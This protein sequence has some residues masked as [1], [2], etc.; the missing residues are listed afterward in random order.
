MKKT[1]LLKPFLTIYIGILSI[2]P[3]QAQPSALSVIPEVKTFEAFDGNLLIDTVATI[4]VKPSERKQLYPIALQLQKEL[5][6]VG[7]KTSIQH[8]P[9][10]QLAI[11]LQQHT[12]TQKQ[13]TESY[14]LHIA[15]DITLSG[16][17][18]IGTY[19]ATRTLLQLILHHDKRLPKGHITDYPDYPNRGF[20]LDVGRKFFSIDLLRHYIKLLSYYKMNEFHIHLNDNG[21]KTDYDNDWS[22][23][24]AAFRL[25]SHT[26][27]GLTA[28]DGHYTKEEFRQ[29][30]LMGQQ[31]GV[32]VIPEIDIPA[33][34]LVFT[35]Y[36][37]Q[38]QAAPP[39]APDH[40][41]ILDDEKLPIIYDFFDK[42]L[43][44]YI[45]G[46]QPTFVGNDVH[47]GTDEF[48]KEGDAYNVDNRQAKRFREFTQHYIDYLANKGKT[49]RLWGGLKWIEDSPKTLVKPTGG[50]IMN[51]W[52]KDWVAP[53]EMLNDGFK[54]INTCDTWLYIV[55]QA[56]Y[57]RDFLDTEWLYKS[58]T[59]SKISTEI[60]LP[61][62]A[63]GLLGATFAV[64]NDKCKNGISQLDVHLRVLPA[65]QVMATK[66]WHTAP[67]KSWEAYSSTASQH[68]EGVGRNLIG[69]YT[70][71][72]LTQMSDNIG[73][74]PIIL[75]GKT[76]LS[77][78]GENLSYDY[79]VSFDLYP[80]GE[81]PSDAILFQSNYGVVTLNTAESGKIGFSRDGYI[82]YFDYI[83]T[84]EVWQ[85]LSIVGNSTSVTLFVDGVLVEKLTSYKRDGYLFQQTFHFPIQMLG[86]EKNGFV[87]MIKNL[88]FKQSILPDRVT[89]KQPL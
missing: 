1:G 22:K 61:E 76:T 54:L 57:Y 53:H 87:G 3:L 65:M 16:A 35:R 14:T 20:M 32:N 39:Y 24:Y 37:P 79:T 25:E 26:Y 71:A 8:K 82:Y 83:P 48:I 43:D 50:A 21:F 89:K 67:T 75:D 40:L 49:P 19:W 68:S 70:T 30:Q 31:Y 2:I 4:I 18:P 51:A 58:F 77:L 42:L 27:P 36:Q 45:D 33:H 74:T 80:Q 17:T 41:G 88:H 9:N 12:A 38:L 81:Q 62:F 59:P 66:T 5:R 72:Q 47:I 69:R 34:S 23:T 44:E 52:S 6:Q 60:T 73:T 15:N 85:S 46:D 84:S 86:D 13:H 29:L 7:I 63:E 10:D 28:T 55:P 78:G 56:G 64:W 11:I